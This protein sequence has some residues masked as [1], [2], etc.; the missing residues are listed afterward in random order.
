MKIGKTRLT[1]TGVN[2]T[3]LDV[4]GIVYPANDMLWMGG[5]ISTELRKAGGISIEQKAMA[6]APAGIG[7]AIVTDA[8]NLKIRWVFHAVISGQDLNTSQETIQKALRACFIKA[9]EIGCRSIA[10]PLMTT[11]VHDIEIH[12]DARIIVDETVNYLV[13][14]KHS[15][16]QVVFIEKDETVRKIITETLLEKFTQHG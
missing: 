15:L 16:E 3:G 11:G 6:Q 4:E 2:I 14:E 9:R 1:I 13:N 10:I 12:L 5:G 8:G 7:E